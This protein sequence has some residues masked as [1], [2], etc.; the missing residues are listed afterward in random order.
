MNVFFVTWFFST[1]LIA[2]A[3]YGYRSFR[4]KKLA[5][6]GE[7]HWPGVLVLSVLVGLAPAL[8]VDKTTSKF[9]PVPDGVGQRPAIMD[10]K[11]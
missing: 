11:N 8:V 9:V 6:S 4:L 2:L 7:F 10:K 1:L 5:G 3:A